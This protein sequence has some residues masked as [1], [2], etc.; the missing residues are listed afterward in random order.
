[1][2]N[3]RLDNNALGC[4]ASGSLYLLLPYDSTNSFYVVYLLL[5]NFPF[6]NV[7]IRI[8]LYHYVLS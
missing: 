2:P 3:L 4:L 7:L 5:T 1:M 8:I 6:K